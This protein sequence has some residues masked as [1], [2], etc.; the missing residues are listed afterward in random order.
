[1]QLFYIN[2]QSASF[3]DAPNPTMDPKEQIR[4]TESFHFEIPLMATISIH[5]SFLSNFNQFLTMWEDLGGPLSSTGLLGS[6]DFPRIPPA[7]AAS[8]S[9]LKILVALVTIKWECDYNL[10][11]PLHFSKGQKKKQL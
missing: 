3:S 10:L 11:R 2:L 6:V 8:A 5:E 9:C 4:V 7:T 1:M